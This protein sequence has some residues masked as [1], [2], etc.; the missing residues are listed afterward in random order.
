MFGL[1]L[2][3]LDNYLVFGVVTSATYL[4]YLYSLFY[5]FDSKYADLIFIFFTKQNVRVRKIGHVTEVLCTR[6]ASVRSLSRTVCAISPVVY[7]NDFFLVFFVKT[8][9]NVS[10]F[11]PFYL[12]ECFFAFVDKNAE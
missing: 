11:F 8:S 1:C 5:V 3:N 2:D 6:L 4:F 7:Q 10:N 9:A 12:G